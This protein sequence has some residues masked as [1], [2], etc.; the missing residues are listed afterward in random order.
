M[1]FKKNTVLIVIVGILLILSLNF[2]QKEVKGFFYT[3]SSPV[4]K[5]FWGVGSGISDFFGG[6]ANFKNIK[7]ENEELK[8]T[9]QGLIAEN[10]ALEELKQENA[11]L[12]EALEVG[13]QKEFRL[14]F[15]E[16]VSKDAGQ[17]SVLINQGYEYGLSEGMPVVTEQNV[18]LGKI[19]EV[20]N[21]FS[22]VT[23]ISD[24]ESSFDAKISDKDITGVIRGKGSSDVDFNLVPQDKE[25]EEGDLIV[26]SSM[27]GVY[28]RNLLVGSVE[29]V[30]KS[31]VKP[32]YEIEVLPFFNIQELDKVFIIL[33]F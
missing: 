21:N 5:Y 11:T 13:L 15:V 12:R 32:F 19:T 30:A 4:Q 20:Y 16:I 22:R 6:I 31:D 7:L 27:G 10:A 14:A 25:I 8:L 24:K 28:P 23:L 3:V 18:L 33:D 17:E 2:F 26:S 9:V 29:R 1:P